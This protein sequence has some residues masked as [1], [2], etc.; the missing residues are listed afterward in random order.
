MR[1][2]IA[3]VVL[4]ILFG[5]SSAQAFGDARPSQCPAKLW[6]GCWL[7]DYLGIRDAKLFHELWSARRWASYGLKASGPAP[8]VIAVFKRGKNG[9]HVGIVTSVPR[10][11][12]IVMKSGNDNGEVRERER[13]IKNVIAWRLP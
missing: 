1:R 9:G 12:V 10:R 7:A 8:G 2:L 13:P 3:A 4:I 5:I 11:G 6:C